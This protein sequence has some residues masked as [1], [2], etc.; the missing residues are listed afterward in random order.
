MWT[1]AM[2]FREMLKKDVEDLFLNTEEFACDICLNGQ[3]IPA[4]V[5]KGDA[6]YDSGSGSGSGFADVSGLGLQITTLTLRIK[7]SDAAGLMPEQAV[8]VDE[9]QWVINSIK[10]E[11]GI[12][13]VVLRQGYA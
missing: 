9:K 3:V 11:D 12:A 1:K 2:T 8:T 6:H 5:D 10:K 13:V 7:Q 4:V